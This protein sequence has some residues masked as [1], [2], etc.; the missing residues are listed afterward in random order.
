MGSAALKAKEK[1]HEGKRMALKE[2]FGNPNEVLGMMADYMKDGDVSSITDLISSYISNSP[3]YN[4]QAE[5]AQAI[6]TTRQ[7]LH[8]MLSH[9]DTV[10]MKVFFGAIEQIYTDATEKSYPQL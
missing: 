5:F 8:R 2:R 9:S 3:K 6:G 10:S 7:T 4:N 1:N